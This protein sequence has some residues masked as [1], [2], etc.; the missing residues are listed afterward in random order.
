MET[1][2]IW[3]VQFT[4]VMEGD[5]RLHVRYADVPLPRSPLHGVT[6]GVGGQ[7]AVAAMSH[8]KVIL[9]GRGLEQARVKVKTMR[10][11]C[12]R[13]NYHPLPP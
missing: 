1:L 12:P 8:D 9:T 4:P 6:S 7:V 3:T 10:I 11:K 2:Q 5:H 13:V